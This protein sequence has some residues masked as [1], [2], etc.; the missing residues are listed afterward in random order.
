MGVLERLKQG[1]G[2]ER[3]WQREELQGVKEGLS[4]VMSFNLR[5]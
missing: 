4:V 1:A 3:S 2:R 5:P